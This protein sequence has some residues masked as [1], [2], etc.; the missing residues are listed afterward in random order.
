MTDPPDAAPPGSGRRGAHLAGQGSGP[1]TKASLLQAVVDLRRDVA[2]TRFPLPVPGVEHAEARRRQLLDQLDDH[3][4]P[5]LREL[6]APA[7]VV[8]AGSTGAGKST[9]VNSLL[10][11]EVSPA[12]VLRPTTRQPVLAHHPDDAELLSDH[13]LLDVVTVVEHA[14]VPPG[15]AVVD[16]PDLDS[17]VATNRSTAHRLLEAA[18][19]WVFVTT[20]ARYGDAVPWAVLESASSRGTSMAIVLNRVPADALVT[21]RSALMSRMRERGMAGVPLFLVHDAGPHEGLLPPAAVAPILRWLRMVA[22][23]DRAR[24]VI[25]RTQRGSLA[26]LRPWVDDLA[27]AVQSQVDARAR[28]ERLVDEAL[29]APLTRAARMVTGGAL[30]SGPVHA[31]WAALTARGGPL[32]GRWTARRG[33]ARREQACG[34]LGSAL[35]DAVTVALTSARAAGADA[36]VES[37]RSTD[38]PGAEGVLHAVHQSDDGSGSAAPDP[39][40]SAAGWLAGAEQLLRHQAEDPATAKALAP[41]VQALGSAG[42]GVVL[43]TAAVGVRGARTAL[44]GLVPVDLVQAAVQLGADELVGRAQEQVRVGA[45]AARVLLGSSDLA[46]DAASHLRLRRAVL[47]GVS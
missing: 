21:V 29:A 26:A 44:N 24:S 7:V 31:R 13:P 20:A 8:L 33:R 2:T 25:A 23:P 45:A 30:A 32:S 1:V 42:S 9:L 11:S 10:G 38:V 41:L 3:L 28:L 5:R 35:R 14:A 12:G 6:S 15:L 22:G 39:A 47:K 46:D 19:L 37:L 27:E 43:A 36:V 16:A 40:E 4:L 18:D 34:E 17:L